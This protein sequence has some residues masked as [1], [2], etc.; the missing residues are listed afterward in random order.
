MS[1]RQCGA[2]NS[3]TAKFCSE[4]GAGLAVVCPSCGAKGTGGKFCSECG[5]AFAGAAAASPQAVVPPPR[6]A[7][8]AER[9]TTSVLFADLVGFTSSSEARDPEET[10]EFLTHYFQTC[11]TVLERYGGTVEKFIGDA[12][13]AVWGVPVAHEDDAERAVRA[14]LDL[15][16]EVAALGS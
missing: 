10:R 1:C 4:C 6:P 2:S 13:M 5:A 3:E 9:R 11:R 14:A 15:V 16:V 12:V 8:V 7:P